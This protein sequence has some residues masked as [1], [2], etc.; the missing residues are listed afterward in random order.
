MPRMLCAAAV[1]VALLAGA[2]ALAPPA[3]AQQSARA[4]VT[5]SVKGDVKIWPAIGGPAQPAGSGTVIFVGDRVE[6]GPQASLQLLMLDRTVFTVGPG[7]SMAIDAFAYDPKRTPAESALAARLTRGIIRYISGDIAA[8]NPEGV[9]LK[10]PVGTIGVRGTALLAMLQPDGDGYVGLLGPGPRN[11]ANLKPGGLAFAPAAGG[12]PIE[13]LRGDSGFVL[14]AG[15]QPGPVGPI[16]R[17][18][19]ARFDAGIAAAAQPALPAGTRTADVAGAEGAARA[20][21]SQAHGFVAT[22]VDPRPGP[23]RGPSMVPPRSPDPQG[24][25][26]SAALVQAASTAGAPALAQI[27]A[28]GA[29]SLVAEQRTLSTFAELGALGGSAS[30]SATGV[31]IRPG[32]LKEPLLTAASDIRRVAETMTDFASRPQIGS[33][34]VS[35][36]VNF[37]TRSSTWS[38]S[39][40][41]VPSMGYTNGTLS[42]FFTPSQP[43]DYSSV[44]NANPGQ[45][46]NVSASSTSSLSPGGKFFRVDGVVMPGGGDP[47]GR[48]FTALAVSNAAGGPPIASGAAILN[49]Q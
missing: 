32:A 49:A 34:D 46:F 25:I 18:V 45:A 40:I 44:A 4:G 41:V 22:A 8:R 37:A 1:G 6:T 26:F 2:A 35:L 48:L 3:H 19:L 38:V 47:R 20:A 28:Q 33:Y 12:A 24:P 23:G 39:N 10:L 30:Y 43:N 21:E 9:N 42:G 27:A 5:A 31:A 29:Q 7:S 36:S 14:G 15:G 17:S 16:P 13:V 11:D